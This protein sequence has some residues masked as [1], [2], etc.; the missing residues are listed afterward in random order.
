MTARTM[1]KS[2]NPNRRTL[3]RW[4]IVAG[5][6]GA[7]H[8]GGLCTEAQVTGVI[9]QATMSGKLG[10]Q[11]FDQKLSPQLQSASFKTKDILQMVL[12]T[13]PTS[14]QVL[15]LNIEAGA[16]GTNIF[17][18]VYDT[19]GRSNVVHITTGERTI[20]F[21]DSKT[22][23]FDV[24]AT[25]PLLNNQFRGGRLRIAGRGKVVNGVPSTLQANVGGTLVDARPGDLGGTTGLLMQTK[26]KTSGK[27]LRVLPASGP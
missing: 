12:G 8:L 17:L 26:L 20:L 13:T 14:T 19:A 2:T 16:T 27:P 23:V 25:V 24:D 5:V 11:G 1:S 9:W 6:V 15:A 3:S 4:M 10:I 18:S 22:V 21:Q 7:C